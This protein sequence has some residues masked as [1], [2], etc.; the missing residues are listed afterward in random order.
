MFVVMQTFRCI[1]S[2]VMV[3]KIGYGF[4]EMVGL[5]HVGPKVGMELCPQ[6]AKIGGPLI[7]SS[8][9]A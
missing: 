4:K 3:T 9:D 2:T 6:T 5:G 1:V 7:R 8:V